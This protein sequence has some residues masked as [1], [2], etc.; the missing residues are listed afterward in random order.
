MPFLNQ[1]TT[2]LQKLLIILFLVTIALSCISLVWMQIEKPGKVT[3]RCDKI[4]QFMQAHNFTF[5]NTTAD[6]SLFTPSCPTTVNPPMS[7][8]LE[9]TINLATVTGIGFLVVS[10]YAYLT[11]KKPEPPSP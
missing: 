7:P 4:N 1:K 5:S 2:T 6:L 8:G 10:T 9:S 3:K 11:R